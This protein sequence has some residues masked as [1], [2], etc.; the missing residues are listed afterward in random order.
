MISYL[1]QLNIPGLG[2]VKAPAGVPQGGEGTLSTILS[3]GIRI[4][5]IVVIIAALVY[6]VWAGIRWIQS[7]GDPQQIDAA[8]K[9]IIFAIIGL[10]VALLSFAIVT[11]FGT[12][13]GVNLL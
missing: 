8:R 10:A 4:F 6:L 3:V 2:E 12:V 9:Q 5:L 7:S 11:I 1:A 13:F